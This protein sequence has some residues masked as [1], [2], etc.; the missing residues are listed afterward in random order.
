MIASFVYLLM[1]SPTLF[2][3]SNRFLYPRRLLKS[4]YALYTYVDGINTGANVDAARK[5]RARIG[6][7]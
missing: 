4:G 5:H 6:V 7:R 3:G 1:H 2:V